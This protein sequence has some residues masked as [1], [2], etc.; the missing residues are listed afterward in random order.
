M[1]IAQEQNDAFI[2]S[3]ACAPPSESERDREKGGV[4]GKGDI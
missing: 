4:G 3:K 1:I 2:S